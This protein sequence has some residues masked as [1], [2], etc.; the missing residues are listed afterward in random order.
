MNVAAA[1]KKGN[2]ITGTEVQKNS[3]N[4]HY[5]IYKGQCVSFFANG[6]FSLESEIVCIHTRRVGDKADSMTDYFPGTF[7]DNLTKA[8]RFVDQCNLMSSINKKDAVTCH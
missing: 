2:K 4:Q 3:D 8:F 1:I 5:W 6:H 7:H